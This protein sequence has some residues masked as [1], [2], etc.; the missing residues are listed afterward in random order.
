MQNSFSLFTR[1]EKQLI[2]SAMLSYHNNITR[3]K[4]IVDK[5]LVTSDKDE[6][7]KIK[8][9]QELQYKLGCLT[10]LLRECAIS[11]APIP[12]DQPAQA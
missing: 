6:W 11:N 8:M 9:Y 2:Y 1:E 5:E 4:I 3:R 7:D 12:K 10:N